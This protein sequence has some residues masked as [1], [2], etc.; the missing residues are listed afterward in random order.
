M[1]SVFFSRQL[2]HSRTL[3]YDLMMH[4]KDV[5]SESSEGA[6][7]ASNTTEETSEETTDGDEETIDEGNEADQ[8][9]L[10]GEGEDGDEVG[11]RDQEGAYSGLVD[12]QKQTAN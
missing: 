1:I 5:E 8:Q 11:D 9:T 10:D 7:E 2:A 3:L 12:A 6:Q 4:L